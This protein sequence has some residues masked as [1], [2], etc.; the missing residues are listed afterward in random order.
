MAKPNECWFVE[1]WAP[2][3]A[4][5]R[6]LED[7]TFAYKDRKSCVRACRAWK[8]CDRPD[9]QYRPALYRR[10]ES[11]VKG[12]EV[13]TEDADAVLHLALELNCTRTAGQ[14]MWEACKRMETFAIN[15]SRRFRKHPEANRHDTWCASFGH[16]PTRPCNCG[17]L[18]LEAAMK[19][20]EEVGK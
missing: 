6:P 10:V 4:E 2:L 7:I 19:A 8:D 20:W 9:A 11:S 15:H 14:A 12:L 13:I 16:Y 17:R 1:W 5:W 18:S 3:S